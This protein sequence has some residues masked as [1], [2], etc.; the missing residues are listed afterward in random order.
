MTNLRHRLATPSVWI[1]LVAVIVVVA[2][3]AVFAVIS[4]GY[5]RLH[6]VPNVD[7]LWAYNEKQQ[8]Y[9]PI[10]LAAQELGT[11]TDTGSEHAALAMNQSGKAVTLSTGDKLWQVNTAMPQ[12]LATAAGNSAIVGKL[13]GSA[14]AY[15]L[16]W[17]AESKQLSV[18]KIG[19]RPTPL[20]ALRASSSTAGNT[21][22]PSAGA[23]DDTGSV[24]VLGGSAGEVF[25]Y[26]H[27]GGTWSGPQKIGTV[28]APVASTFS[29]DTPPSMT[30]FGTHWAALSSDGQTL[31][32]DGK[33]ANVQPTQ[34][35]ASAKLAVAAA[36]A[37]RLL[38]VNDSGLTQV[39]D[40]GSVTG[41]RYAPRGANLTAAAPIWQGGVAY[42]TWLPHGDNVAAGQ[43][44]LAEISSAGAVH[45]LPVTT[46]DVG[47][48]AD[49]Q[50]VSPVFAANGDALMVN[51]GYSGRVWVRDGAHWE[52]VRSSANWG[53]NEQEHQQ[54][55]QST[56]R[57]LRKT[58]QCP[59]PS[60]GENIK[61]GVR[62]GGAATLPVLL[63]ATDQNVGD[64]VSIVDDPKRAP[65]IVGAPAGWRVTVSNNDR[66]L[67]ITAPHTATVGSAVD[68][69]YAI[70]DGFCVKAAQVSVNVAASNQTDGNKPPEYVDPPEDAKPTLTGAPDSS[71][72]FNALDRWVDPDGDALYVMD[73]TVTGSKAARVAATPEG[74][75][76]VNTDHVKSANLTVTYTV[77]DGSAQPQKHSTQISLHTQPPLRTQ[78]T[79]VTVPFNRA[80]TVDIGRAFV[81]GS[82]GVTINNIDS[83]KGAPA[84]AGTD[85]A[86]LSV[87]ASDKAGS[88]IYNYHA[89]QLGSAAGNS[90]A[91]VTGAV[92]VIVQHE[93]SQLSVPPI[94]VFV[95]PDEDIVVDALAGATNPSGNAMWIADVAD[96]IR[97]QPHSGGRGSVALVGGNK[98]KVNAAVGSPG[99][100]RVGTFTYTVNGLDSAGHTQTVAALATVIQVSQTVK[101][102]V[103]VDDHYV[104]QAGAQLDF[105]VLDN[106]ISP[107]G[108]QL[109]L[110]PRVRADDAHAGLDFTTAGGLAFATSSAL[111][112]LAPTTPGTY[113]VPYREYVADNSTIS[114]DGKVTLDVKARPDTD[115]PPQAPV[116]SGTVYGNSSTTLR[117]PNTS[118]DADG[119]A[120]KIT[121]VEQPPH[122]SAEPSADGRGVVVHST[123]V[124]GVMRFTYTVSDGRQ[125]QVGQVTVAVLRNIPKSVVTYTD[126]VEFDQAT[127]GAPVAID[128]TL[129]DEAPDGEAL[130]VVCASTANTAPC[131]SQTASVIKPTQ[132]AASSAKNILQLRPNGRSRTVYTYVVSTPSAGS[133]TGTIIMTPVAGA[134]YL[135]Q[136]P[137]VQDTTVTQAQI[138]Q[139]KNTYSVPMQ[140]SVNW[141][142]AGAVRLGLWGKHPGT[143]VDHG[144]QIK[145]VVKSGAAQTVVYSWTAGHQALHGQPIVSYGFLHVP[146]LRDVVP[147]LRT[148]V[149]PI[150][151][152]QDAHRTVNLNSTSF[153][154]ASSVRRGI[155]FGAQSSRASG[156]RTG[157]HC[158]VSSRG[159]LTYAAGSDDINA[160]DSCTV[161]ARWRDAPEGK[162]GT[163]VIPI[164]VTLKNPPP[165][166]NSVTLGT[167]RPDNA[168]TVF[169]LNAPT[170]TKWTAQHGDRSTL[171]Y[172]CDPTTASGVTIAC[173]ANGKVIVTASETAEQ[174]AN[175]RF[176]AWITSWGNAGS[177]APQQPP[178]TLAVRV[179]M[180]SVRSL[181]PVAIAQTCTEGK[182]CAVDVVKENHDIPANGKLTLQDI[183]PDVDGTASAH[184]STVNINLSGHAGGNYQISYT[185]RDDSKPRANVGTGLISVAYQ[186]LP[187]APTVSG[188]TSTNGTSARISVGVPKANPD[189]TTLLVNANGKS[190]ECEVPAGGLQAECVITGLRP[191]VKTTVTLYSVNAAGRSHDSTAVQVYGYVPP[192]A[193]NI[194]NWSAVLNEPKANISFSASDTDEW[195][196][197]VD[198]KTVDTG[199][200]SVTGLT[201][202]VQYSGSTV[203]VQSA[204]PYG[205]PGGGDSSTAT[206]AP[207]TI[208]AVQEARDV[209][210]T[211]ESV[212]DANSASQKFT[213]SYSNSGDKATYGFAIT[214]A[215]TCPDQPSGGQAKTIDFA[216]SEL[217][218]AQTVIGCV[219]LTD[220]RVAIRPGPQSNSVTVVPFKVPDDLTVTYS[221]DEHPTQT[222]GGYRYQAHWDDTSRVHSDK[223]GTNFTVSQSKLGNFDDNVRPQHSQSASIC[224]VGT[225]SCGTGKVAVAPSDRRKA[226]PVKVAVS[227]SARCTADG[228]L[229][230][231]DFAADVTGDAAALTHIGDVDV[232]SGDH[233]AITVSFR[234]D[235][236]GLS[237][238]TVTS[239]TQTCTPASGGTGGSDGSGNGTGP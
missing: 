23:V 127:P 167:A 9:A 147:E 142:G 170:V 230:P 14:G 70:T 177:R 227:G 184:G 210:L 162:H 145:G 36:A 58:Q 21:V 193:I 140:S 32:I 180:S 75:V 123:A 229:G 136:F 215:S 189:V 188:W 171:R 97:I 82:Q 209:S 203:R 5:E 44:T 83:P 106:D 207:A 113:V 186:A 192:K 110:D 199:S 48:S 96:N 201:I 163:L 99:G 194:A 154:D 165:T 131:D 155:V 54:V 60:N 159:S 31:V 111:R 223:F 129:N 178:A 213:L 28:P 63:A 19:R 156:V 212:G 13:W 132:S 195:A 55:K 168:P 89:G 92:R 50:E 200:G 102:P 47:L 217:Y 208:Y 158:S 11:P 57:Q 220:S 81:G 238:I 172:R 39:A 232:S 119:D 101:S 46:N 152:R 126:Y 40:N 76:I 235:L 74:N 33:T 176:K 53:I 205:P 1:P 90:S 2:L 26:K 86:R 161:T 219:Y 228:T 3:V 216:D 183:H 79:T 173:D 65:S 45:S 137:I 134:D 42:A 93:T 133:V 198:G 169:Q 214:Q 41:Q 87:E 105:D 78:P 84:M 237:P 179:G 197:I 139:P 174:G 164:A 187:A 62:Q 135:P 18:G 141:S 68:V 149:R 77:G 66:E 143:V 95:S 67:A 182:P 6:V 225:S 118:L 29:P 160:T 204:T 80:A 16:L 98:L 73:T 61:F 130:N 231:G 52:F 175:V 190:R 116:L 211:A 12:N 150:A 185:L 109:V 148:D 85:P 103:A 59:S 22:L 88:F 4:R 15:Q 239:T 120:V 125:S 191:F 226:M 49:T 8:L 146:A 153:F 27:A 115:T 114:A 206:G 157:A 30:T 196:V 17:N 121:A 56:D 144:Q 166:L 233:A 100:G 107:Q 72:A 7:T 104:I 24:V 221:V 25:R 234:D 35:G 138:Q 112:V 64:V 43:A 51:D 71:I 122:G 128:P 202:P 108:K 218:T 38:I 236:G 124:S 20:G 151:V 224:L 117:L 10:N 222:D 34:L 94:T 181:F 91:A 37:S 69:R